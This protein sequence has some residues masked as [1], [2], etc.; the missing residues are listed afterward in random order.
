LDRLDWR[1]IKD[2]VDLARV[3][4]AFLGPA[5]K[6]QGRILLWRCPFHKDHDPSFQVDSERKTW[7]CWPCNLGGDAIELVEQVGK[8]GFPEAVRIAAEL[9]GIVAA[10]GTNPRP[11]PRPRPPATAPTSKPAKAASPRLEQW[12][13]LPLE[14]ASSLVTEAA[15]RLWKPEGRQPLAYL[16]GRCLNDET[17]KAARLGWT[18]GV[19][20]PTRDGD[21]CYRA[22]GVVIPWFDGNRLALVK[23]RQPEGTEPKYAE[24]FRDRPTLYP[25]PEAIRQGWP[26]VIPE[27]EFDRLLLAQELRDL[28]AVVT[29][30]SASV[31]PDPGIRAR[32]LTA[33]IWFVAHDADSG[34][35]RA[36][37]EWPARA[38]R[39]RPPEQFNDWTEAA[40][41]G[42]N[43]RLWWAARLGRETL[44]RELAVLRWGPARDDP[45]PGIIID[46][47]DPEAMRA[48]LASADPFD[49]YALAERQAIQQENE[50]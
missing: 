18:P 47:P 10:S 35:D 21:R 32:V 49:A 7:K 44:W 29:L 39:I 13:G 12:S 1:L 22:R 3:A 17:I 41:A 19:M 33:P 48:A 27:G 25:G 45:T 31:R 6:R 8:V 38:R 34:G 42:V 20:I 5:A 24:A 36:A 40:R 4:A 43:L 28:A 9:S 15:D 26:L 30:G 37:S 14:E 11:A 46:R 50:P 2:R 23:I 16:H